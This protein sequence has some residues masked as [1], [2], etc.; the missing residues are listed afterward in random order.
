MHYD[1]MRC[2]CPGQLL[3]ADE[4]GKDG[5][6]HAANLTTWS[7]IKTRV[8]GTMGRKLGFERQKHQSER[9]PL[10]AYGTP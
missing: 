10:K 5:M 6:V 3:F 4:E 7:I 9:S 1:T 8:L 2:A